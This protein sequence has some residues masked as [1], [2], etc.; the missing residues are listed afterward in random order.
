MYQVIIQKS[1][2]NFKTPVLQRIKSWS[3]LI[4]AT[5]M[6]TAEL[7][8]RI[9]SLSEIIDLN[10]RYRHKN[11]ATNVLSFPFESPP[12]IKETP[13]LGDI[14]ICAEVVIQ[15][16]TLQ[17]KSSEAHWAH[18][19]VHGILHLLGYDHEHE[20][21]ANIMEEQEIKLLQQ[22]GFPNPY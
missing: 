9:V 8:I 22:L 1:D 11:S 18:M 17:N 6:A 15:E 2:R 4:L 14:V 7:V 3:K 10:S 21:E 13:F 16:A 20:A 19:I 12:E 5:H